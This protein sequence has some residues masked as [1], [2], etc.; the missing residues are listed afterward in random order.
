[1][2]RWRILKKKQNRAGA[3]NLR[4]LMIRLQ[5]LDEYDDLVRITCCVLTAPQSHRITIPQYRIKHFH[6][7]KSLYR[8][9]KIQLRI[10]RVEDLYTEKTKIC[11]NFPFST[12]LFDIR[13]PAV[14]HP[15]I[16]HMICLNLLL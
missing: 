11:F 4:N 5:D 7:I 14:R 3:R 9:G 13:R 15:S 1:M 12:K 16:F 6:I 2:W 10:P 8:I